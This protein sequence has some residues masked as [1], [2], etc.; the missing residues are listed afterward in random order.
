M[1]SSES[2]I[3]EQVNLDQEHFPVSNKTSN[4]DIELFRNQFICGDALT[5]MR[6][7]S[8]NSIDLVVTSVPYNL[9]NSTGNGMKD[10]R[11]GKW[12]NAALVNGYSHHHD[13]MPH[14]EY[15][16]WQRD[17]L[18]EMYRLIKDGAIF[19]NHKWRVQAGLLK[20]GCKL[21]SECSHV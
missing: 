16:Q 1:Q 14:D 7:M 5:V 2:E 18:T 6:E 9:K 8:D 17:C 20:F 13:N 4:R 12:A 3:V 10:R 15:A 21:I 19:Y 11:G